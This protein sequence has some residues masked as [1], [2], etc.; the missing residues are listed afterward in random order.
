MRENVTE[1][2]ASILGMQNGAWEYDQV[3]Y[4]GET[5]RDENGYHDY[6]H[7]DVIVR[8]KPKEKGGEIYGE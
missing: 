1:A 2:I 5:D 3:I 4:D 8:F 7:M 6:K